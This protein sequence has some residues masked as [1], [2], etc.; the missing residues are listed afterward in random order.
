MKKKVVV[1]GGGVAGMSAAHELAER[2]F[3]VHV[4]EA[5][6][7]PG[8][9]ARSILVNNSGTNGRKNLP[10][11][12]G[13]RF[14][15]GFYQHVTD[16]MKRIPY[17][18]NPN[19]V[20]DNL[21]DTA[22]VFI[23]RFDLEP[24]NLPAGTPR[25]IDEIKANIEVFFQ[26]ISNEIRLEEGELIF[27]VEKIWQLITSSKERRIGEH[28]KISWWDYLEAGKKSRNYQNFLAKGLTESLVASKA[29]LASTKTAGDIFLQLLFDIITIGRNADRVLNGPTSDVWINPWLR[30]L[31]NLGVD[32]NFNCLVKS[33]NY[34]EERGIIKNI[35][36]KERRSNGEYAEYEVEGDYYVAAFPIEIMAKLIEISQLNRYES[37]F[38]N[39]ITLARNTAWMNGIQ[40]YLKEDVEVSYG[41]ALYVDTP[42]AL[43]S[44]S[45]KQ[46]WPNVALSEYGDG[47]V[48]GILSVVISDW[49]PYLKPKT[50]ADEDAD[51]GVFVKKYAKDC[52]SEEIKDEVW[53]QLKKSLTVNGK[54]ILKDEN[55]HSWFMDPDIVNVELELF[56]QITDSKGEV[57]LEDVK[58][59]LKQKKDVHDEHVASVL[60]RTLVDLNFV[61]KIQGKDEEGKDE[62]FYR[63]RFRLESNINLEPLLVN[64][65]NTWQLRPDAFTRIPNLFLA[66]DYI[67]T[68]TDLATMEGANEA[69]RR[70][71]NSIIS[72]SGSTAPLCKI[73]DL[74]EPEIFA[75]LRWLDSISYQQGLPWGGKLF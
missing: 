17:K 72:V 18:N 30:H 40:F 64:L 9:K 73:W 65:V 22:R 38:K 34:D 54:E 8:G 48:K 42:W 21:V 2:G 19:G 70:A 23:A 51:R 68:N 74:H 63:P 14:F 58:E 56:Q 49:G 32:Y 13:L 61:Q 5:R 53:A 71:V 36:I 3:H 33:L 31:Q 6:P 12:H 55:L 43:T 52:T 59:Y 28:E 27:F 1:L 75:P 69:A 50:Q 26:I 35:T 41:H 57:R 60:L 46:F 11:E 16:T 25:T 37:T 39:I 66:S 29:K 67:R 45:Q 15:P 47:Q 10:G 44:I 24:V 20:F 62:K 4:Y 7:V